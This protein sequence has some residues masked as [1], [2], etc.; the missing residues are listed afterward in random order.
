M[1]CVKIYRRVFWAEGALYENQE[2]DCTARAEGVRGFEV[3][4]VAVKSC[5][6]LDTTVDTLAFT[7]SELGSH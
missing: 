2:G 3:R 1:N 6:A 7:V 4:K 5:R